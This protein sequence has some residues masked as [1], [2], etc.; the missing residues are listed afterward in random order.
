M[1]VPT[2]AIFATMLSIFGS[3][4]LACTPGTYYCNGTNIF[5]CNSASTGVLS[6]QCGSGGCEAIGSAAY[7]L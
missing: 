2:L 7:C 5:V 6:A 1:Q 4:A 3:Q